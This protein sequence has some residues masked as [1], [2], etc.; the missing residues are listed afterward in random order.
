MKPTN[1]FNEKCGEFS[2][3][4]LR[5]GS[6][7]PITDYSYQA[8]SLA[9]TG[10]RCLSSCRPSFRSISQDYFENE[11]PRSLVSEAAFFSV[12]M[13]TASL[14]ILNSA[15]ALVNVLRAIGTF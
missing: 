2:A 6:A 8:A 12:M 5:C 10:T 1:Q 13:M 11:E 4:A 7:L 15:G 9:K 14:L 3:R